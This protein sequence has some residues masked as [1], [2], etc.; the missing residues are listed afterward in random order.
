[1][2]AKD[3]AL[4]Y[5]ANPYQTP[6]RMFAEEGELPVQVLNGRPGYINMLDLLHG[7]QLVRELKA[8]LNLPAAASY[9]HV[10]P[11]GAA[12]GT[13]LSQKLRRAHFVQDIALTP[14][15]SA[16]ARA[17]GADRMSSYGDAIALSDTCDEATA[18]V[19]SREVSDAVIAP[20]YEPEAL[21]ILR[22]KRNGGYVVLQI[23]PTYEPPP[24]ERRDIF[25]ITL[26]QQR[27]DRV[28]GPEIFDV[29]VTQNKALPE[30]ARRDLILATIAL[31]YTQSNSVC[32]V[33]D[34]QI[35]GL[36]AGQQSRIHCMRL[37]AAKAQN[38][39]LRQHPAVFDLPFRRGLARAEM[40][41][42]I[43]LFLRDEMPPEAEAVWRQNFFMPPKRLT[44]EEKAEWLRSLQGVSLS[45]DAFFPFRDNI[46]CAHEVGGK[47]IVQPGGSLRDDDITA[48]CDE[49]GMVM[50]HSGVRLFTH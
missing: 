42:V 1:M 49:Y 10:S 48:A 4:R 27:N 45:S 44:R 33:L 9:K 12:V 50:A 5:G 20:A 41:N 34:G 16:Y 2:G 17:R 14:L 19:I 39:R 15:A 32:L 13:S 43:D 22:R 23:D 26:E 38:W 11:T 18:R 7:W 31:K 46:E 21:T 28:I 30:S 6:A 36:G 47:Y 25:G 29:I 8:A 40:N 3:V 37:A 35:I 24:M